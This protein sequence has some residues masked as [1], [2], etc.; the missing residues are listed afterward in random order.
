M[1]DAPLPSLAWEVRLRADGCPLVAGV[2]EAGRGPLAGPVVAAAV[3]LPVEFAHA[4]LNDSKKLSPGKRERICA[5]LQGDAGIAWSWAV[6]SVEEIDRLNILK[7]SHLAMERAVNGL[8]Q[9]PDAVLIDGLEVHGFPHRQQALVK[10]DSISLSIA[11]AS[12]IAKVE[13]DRLMRELAESY[14]EYGFE[15]HKGYP[16]K[17]HLTLLQRHGPCPVHRQTFGP[18]A[19]LSLPFAEA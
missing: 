7:A 5:E 1:P 8:P 18:V 11:A 10:G 15:K 12:I 13:R 4:L 2:D 19:Q 6:A 17:E 16:T 14:P 3:I 9:K